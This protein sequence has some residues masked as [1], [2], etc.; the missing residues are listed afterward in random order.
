MMMNVLLVSLYC[1]LILMKWILILKSLISWVARAAVAFLSK[2]SFGCL[3]ALIILLIL[4][5]LLVI[6]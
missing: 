3:L 2:S 4:S 5:V 1:N 6:V